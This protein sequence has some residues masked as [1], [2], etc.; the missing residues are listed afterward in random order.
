LN[1]YL[2]GE[3]GYDKKMSFAKPL[4]LREEGKRM[5]YFLDRSGEFYEPTAF[6]AIFWAKETRNK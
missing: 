6:D 3:T 5:P 2:L 4:L 1:L